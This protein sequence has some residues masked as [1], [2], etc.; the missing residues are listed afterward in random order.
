MYSSAKKQGSHLGLRAALEPLLDKYNV[1]LTF[2]GHDHSYVR[3]THK[4]GRG[5]GRTG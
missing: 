2:S 1:Q 4:T 5:P 3:V